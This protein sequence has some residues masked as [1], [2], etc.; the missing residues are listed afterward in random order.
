M[1]KFQPGDKV[2]RIIHGAWGYGR[3]A[4]VLGK[5]PIYSKDWLVRFDP[6]YNDAIP[7]WHESSMVLAEIFF[8]PL[9]QEL[10]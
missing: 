10:K 8:S 1:S 2:V 4:T 9:F 6:D 7:R 3:E 5:C